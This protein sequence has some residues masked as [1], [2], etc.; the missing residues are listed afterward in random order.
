VYLSTLGAADTLL[1]VAGMLGAV[2]EIPC[3][4]WADHLVR[5]RGTHQLL[6]IAMGLTI[7]QRAL[8]LFAPTIATIMLT[9]AT[10][11]LS[12][13]FYVVALTAFIGEETRP[14]ETGTVLALF[15]VTLAGIVN[16]VSAPLAGAA[17]DAFGAR[18]LYAIAV[19][20]YALGWVCLRVTR[21]KRANDCRQNEKSCEEM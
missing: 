20:G 9:R 11:G 5:R 21:P 7:A 16:I 1:G 12:F 4:L 10:T 6:L 8:V 17:Y 3:M 2:V 18:W 13:S 15:S 14:D 19:I